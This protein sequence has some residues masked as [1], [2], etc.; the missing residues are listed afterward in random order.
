MGESFVTADWLCCDNVERR[1]EGIAFAG[2]DTSQQE[3]V[4]ARVRNMFVLLGGLLLVVP[5]AFAA[6]KPAPAGFKYC[7][8]K[9]ACDVPSADGTIVCPFIDSNDDRLKGEL[10]LARCKQFYGAD[11]EYGNVSGGHPACKIQT[12]MPEASSCP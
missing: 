5:G 4:M 3:D 7:E 2:F 9:T 10:L 11:T 6:Q 12:L 1:V 8:V